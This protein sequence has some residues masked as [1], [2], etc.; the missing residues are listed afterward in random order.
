MIQVRRIGLTGGIATGKTTVARLLADRH[1][2]PVLDADRFAREVLAPGAPATLAVVG[3][4]GDAV[5]SRDPA[6][7]TLTLDRPALARIVFASEAERRWLEQL[8]HPIVRR[9]FTAALEDLEGEAVV[10]LMIP[11]LFEAGL[12]PLCS[13]IWVVE[14]GSEDEQMRRLQK[15]DGIDREEARARLSAQWPMAAKLARADVVIT[16]RGSQD[17]LVAQV[18]RAL[19]EPPPRKV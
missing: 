4:Y 10:V 9:R 8:V 6:N 16:N 19:A 11:L 18:D 17:S 14:C 2:I 1:G 13:E 3:R 5:C 15:R 7:T 12:Q